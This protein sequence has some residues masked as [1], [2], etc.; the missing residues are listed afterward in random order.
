MNLEV[1]KSY[2]KPF[3]LGM[4]LRNPK[5]AWLLFRRATADFTEVAGVLGIEKT[6]L[7]TYQ[8]EIKKNKDFND[9]LTEKVTNLQ[10]QIISKRL[11]L[12]SLPPDVCMF[13][14]ALV[15]SLKPDVILETGVASGMSTSYLLAAFEANENGELYSV[16]LPHETVNAKLRGMAEQYSLTREQTGWLVPSE[17]RKRWTLLIGKSSEVLPGTL[18]NLDKI[19]IFLHDSAHTY[20]NMMFEYKTAWPYIKTGGVLLSDN[21]DYNEAFSDFAG[22]VQSRKFVFGSFGVLV[23]GK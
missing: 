7:T 1:F 5:S 13:I 6:L 10:S 14:Y 22:T 8:D 16:D 15:R 17:L 18:R 2:I 23:K 3:Y 21:I 4:A 12:G 19:D 11:T 20:E 9:S